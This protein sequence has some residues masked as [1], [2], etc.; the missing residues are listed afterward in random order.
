[1]F[2]EYLVRIRFT[3]GATKLRYVNASSIEIEIV[4]AR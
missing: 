3:G 2:G 4:A 1:L